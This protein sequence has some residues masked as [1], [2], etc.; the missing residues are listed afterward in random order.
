MLALVMEVSLPKVVLLVSVSR[1]VALVVVVTALGDCLW[2]DDR[3]S[4]M[5][6]WI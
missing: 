6:M 5:Y 4:S 3:I 2:L 1:V